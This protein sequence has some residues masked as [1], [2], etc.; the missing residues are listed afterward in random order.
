MR[1]QIFWHTRRRKQCINRTL[2]FIIKLGAWR[3]Y[4]DGNTHRHDATLDE[5]L[6]YV[7]VCGVRLRGITNYPVIY[8]AMKHSIKTAYV[9][10]TKDLSSWTYVG[11]RS[12]INVE[13][14][15]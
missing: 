13:R 14:L 5:R 15:R 9:L 6:G 1:V 10:K 3:R 4:I 8:H 7:R 11:K 2:V 12:K